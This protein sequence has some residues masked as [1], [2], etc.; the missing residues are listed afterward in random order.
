MKIRGVALRTACLTMLNPH[1]L[2]R[3]LFPLIHGGDPA[4]YPE[5]AI[6]VLLLIARKRSELFR[7]LHQQSISFDFPRKLMS[8]KVQWK[9]RSTGRY[10]L[11]KFFCWKAN[12]NNFSRSL[13]IRR[14]GHHPT[15]KQ[16]NSK[17]L[18]AGVPI[19]S[20]ARDINSES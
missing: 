13:F 14:H 18:N 12:S 6:S 16:L 8:H 5:H 4:R 17:I 15:G 10:C 9:I 3:T 7:N 2:F 1:R 20:G 11:Q 19:T